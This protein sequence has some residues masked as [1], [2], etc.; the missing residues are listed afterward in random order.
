M[1]PRPGRA[2]WIVLDGVGL[3]ALPDAACYG[4]GDA[5]TLPH[6]AAACGGL[7]LP[8]LQRLGLGHLAA[9]AGVPPHPAPCGG[10]GRMREVAAGKDSISGHWEMA[11]VTLEEP[12]ATYPQGFPA[13]LIEQ[14]TT[15]AGCAPLGNV[16]ASGTS[17]LGVYGAEHL[18]TGRPILY[19]SVDSVLQIAAHEA[20]LAEEE[21]YH[22]CRRLRMLADAY[23]IGRVI[24]RPFTGDPVAGFRR[25]A[26]R[27]DFPMPAPRTTLFDRLCNEQV[28]VWAVGKLADL[29]AGRSIA[30]VLPTRDNADGMRRILEAWDAL[31]Q[32]ALLAA[33]LI[34]FDMIYG[35][36]RDAK[37]FGRALEAFDTWLPQLQARMTAD[38]LLLIAADHGCDPLTPG[39]DH[40]REYVPILGWQPGLNEA[41]PLGERATMADLGAT[42]AE[43][44][45]VTL[46]NGQ[47]FLGELRQRGG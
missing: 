9:I 4:D 37:G 31:P 25:T 20:V 33:N 26:G 29:F 1:T 16:S 19:T 40:T 3:G 18:K 47:S 36:R 15:V 45:G 43:F 39:T 6:V 23:H 7:V 21:L 10:F 12:F 24:A 34:D 27:K 2:A 8:H 17:I 5:A 44:F 30:R 46:P 35:H 22:L 38:D 11:G 41:R 42:L 32:P 14:I 28:P 13:E